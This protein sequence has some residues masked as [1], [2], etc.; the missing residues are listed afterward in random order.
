MGNFS[1]LF[2]AVTE[3]GKDYWGDRERIAKRLNI[4]FKFLDAMP[5]ERV[6]KAMQIIDTK[7]SDSKYLYQIFAHGFDKNKN[8][9]VHTSYLFCALSGKDCSKRLESYMTQYKEE[10]IDIRRIGVADEDIQP[11]LLTIIW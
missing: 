4:I 9:W 5:A 11:G 10:Y 1:D 2:F 6:L 7:E 8:K 3:E